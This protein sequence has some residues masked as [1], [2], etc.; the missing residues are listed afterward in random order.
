MDYTGESVRA[1]LARAC[2]K[3]AQ[4]CVRLCSFSRSGFQQLQVDLR[5]LR[6]VLGEFV[7]GRSGGSDA[8]ALARDV[9]A[10]LDAAESDARGR[11]TDPTPL[12]VSVIEHIL[13]HSEASRQRL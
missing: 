11:C 5:Y 2:C 4:E 7:V 1:A 13:K 6:G 3:T 12:E 10:L 9:A 8:A